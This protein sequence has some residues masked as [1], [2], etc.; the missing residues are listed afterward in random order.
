M[1]ILPSVLL[2]AAAANAGAALAPRGKTRR[3]VL[4]AVSLATLLSLLL[5]VLSA[6]G[7]LPGVPA[8]NFPED[9]IG[10]TGDPA[11]PVAEAANVAL[12]REISRR[13]GVTPTGVAITLPKSETDR[14]SIRVTLADG[15]A[16]LAGKIGAWL[17]VE[18]AAGTKIEV[19][20]SE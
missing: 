17:A 18:S 6:L 2:V 11:D 12:S 15:D 1:K 20:N 8:Q 3:A 5:P 10:A 4:F 7:D 14:G 9:R 13:F 19:E 16:G